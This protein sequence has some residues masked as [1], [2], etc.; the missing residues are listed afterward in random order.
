MK[1]FVS[2]IIALVLVLSVSASASVVSKTSTDTTQVETVESMT[3]GVVI[4]EGF[5]VVVTPDAV[6]VVEEIKSMFVFVN[7]EKQAPVNYFPE[8]TK[9]QIKTVLAAKLELAPE[10]DLSEVINLEEMEINEFVTFQ[11]VEYKEEYGD[12]KVN[13]TFV[14]EYAQEQNL[15]ALVSL[16]NGEV[17]EEGKQIVEWLVLEAEALEDG[18]VAVVIPQAE[19]LKIQSAQTSALLILSEKAAEEVVLAE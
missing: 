2:I 13:F 18:T 6:E 17:D 19:M 4:E 3:E 15:V 9:E 12:V 16:F 7:E 1:K 8:E 5:A 11:T 10:A 14:T